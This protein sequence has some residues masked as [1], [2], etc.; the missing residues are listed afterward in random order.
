MLKN[1]L[2]RFELDHKVGLLSM[3][4]HIG[5]LKIRIIPVDDNG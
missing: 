1:N 4:G 5:F 2:Y 3:D